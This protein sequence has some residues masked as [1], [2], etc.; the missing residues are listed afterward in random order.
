MFTYPFPAC[1][2]CPSGINTTFIKSNSIK[3]N[4]NHKI[5]NSPRRINLTILT[6]ILFTFSASHVGK[7][8]HNPTHLHRA[9]WLFSSQSSLS[10]LVNSSTSRV[11]FCLM[12]EHTARASTQRVAPSQFYSLTFKGKG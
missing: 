11:P 8:K 6:E 7:S 3:V 4:W 5:I 12:T 10:L 1:K 2:Y 9:Q